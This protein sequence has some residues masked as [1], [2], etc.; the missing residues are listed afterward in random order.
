MPYLIVL[1]GLL[2]ALLQVIAL[3]GFV[4]LFAGNELDLGITLAAWLAAVGAGSAA[5]RRV[6]APWAFGAAVLSS[7]LL[8]Y[9]LLSLVPH[10]RAHLGLEPGEVLSLGRTLAATALVLTPLCF[11]LGMQ[12][13]LAASALGGRAAAAYLLEA[14]GACGGGLLFTFLLAGRVPAQT[15]LAALCVA[16]TVTG[17]VLLRRKTLMLAAL[18]PVALVVLRPDAFERL[19]EGQVL[20]SQRESR[21]GLIEVYR[22]REQNNVYASGRFLYAYPDRPNEE[23]RA[24]LPLLL[25]PQ[26]KRVLIAGGSP[27]LVR[28]VLK[29]RVSAVDFVDLDPALIAAARSLLTA[30]D[31]AAFQ[32]RR[33]TV[34]AVD[35]RRFIKSAAGAGYDLIMLNLPEPSTANANRCYTVEFFREARSALGPGGVVTLNLPVSFGYVGKRLQSANGAIL[36]SLGLAF[37]YTAVS[38]EEYGILAGSDWPIDT[39]QRELGRRL[40]ERHGA[41]LPVHPF[42][43]DDAFDQ[44]KTT[45]HRSRLDAVNV[46]NRDGRPVAYLYNLLVWAEMQRSGVLLFLADNGRALLVSLL[47]LAAGAGMML[48]RGR[49]GVS[50]T[51]FLSGTTAMSFSVVI[52]LAYQSAFGHVYERVGLLTASFMAGSAAGAFAARNVAR[53]LRHLQLAAAG[54]LLA[55]LTA[56]RFFHQEPLFPVV[57]FLAGALGGAMFSAAARFLADDAAAAGRLYALDLAGSVFGALLTTLVTVPLFGIGRALL[58]IAALQGISLAVLFT[59]GHEST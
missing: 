31:R 35:A 50:Y 29:D 27:A 47:L 37:R 24:H 5:G 43:I 39:G 10:L 17:A 49:R 46:V 59:L 8:A 34:H 25:H 51:V 32:D 58:F 38:S 3:R 19:R 56:P 44:L 42:V 18:L 11:L 41:L 12:F 21:Y 33:V 4:V 30:E 20:V 6:T 26:P 48:R 28:E 52:L 13:P 15:I 16:G 57:A 54:L 22:S 36:R 1:L 53:P 2:T 9:P 45:M 23:L 40:R 55:A 14:A 7:F